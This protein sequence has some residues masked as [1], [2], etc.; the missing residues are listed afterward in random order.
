M[1]LDRIL[2]YWNDLVCNVTG[3]NQSYVTEMSWLLMSLDR[4]NPMLLECLG[5]LCHWIESILC[6]RNDLASYVAGSNQSCVT[7]L[8]QWM[9]WSFQ[10]LASL[11]G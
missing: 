7:G 9:E 6:Y 11:C 3:S 5:F 10:K 2:C 4:I 8:Y 1:S